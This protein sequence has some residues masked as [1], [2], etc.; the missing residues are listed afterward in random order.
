LKWGSLHNYVAYKSVYILN[1]KIG[2]PLEPGLCSRV[3]W[4]IYTVA[5]LEF[6]KGG[7]NMPAFTLT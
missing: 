1:T 3:C 5:D 6:S 7:K 4:D 2:E